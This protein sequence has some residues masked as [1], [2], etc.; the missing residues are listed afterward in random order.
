MFKNKSRDD[1]DNFKK[2]NRYKKFKSKPKFLKNY[3][4]NEKQNYE[5]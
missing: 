5:S 2:T 3:I 1:D 4:K